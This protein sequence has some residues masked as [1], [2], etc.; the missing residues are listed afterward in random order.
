V[1]LLQ[2][3]VSDVAEAADGIKFS[4]PKHLLAAMFVCGDFNPPVTKLQT[5]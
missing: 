4:M 5:L 2:D 3:V 1:S